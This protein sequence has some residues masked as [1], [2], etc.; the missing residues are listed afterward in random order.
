ML[1]RGGREQR[2]RRQGVTDGTATEITGVK[3]VD[4]NTIT[5]TFIAPNSL[6]PTSISELFILPEAHA[7]ATIPP[8]R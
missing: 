1:L 2:R 3:V 7:R 4:R 5:F 8:E 6:F